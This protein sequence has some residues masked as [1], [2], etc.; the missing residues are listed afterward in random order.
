MT[1]PADTPRW[2]RVW[3]VSRVGTLPGFQESSPEA[4]GVGKGPSRSQVTT[5][6]SLP[7]VTGCQVREEWAH[8][9]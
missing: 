7:W 8:G 1:K 6:A 5:A 9:V 2:R 3:P 4:S